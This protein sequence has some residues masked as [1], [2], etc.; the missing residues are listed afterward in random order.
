MAGAIDITQ[1]DLE[2]VF[3]ATTVRQVFCDNGSAVAGRRLQTAIST[4]RRELDAVLL[5]GWPTLDAIALLVAEDDS[6]KTLACRLVMAEGVEGKAEW[7]GEGAPFQHLRARTL[8]TLELLAAG[9]KRSAGETV[10]GKNRNARGAVSPCSP[11]TMF[12]PTRD[13]PIRRGF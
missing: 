7:S 12:A 13:K 2:A 4:A 10:A 5:K 6:I 3:P 8:A 9:Q 11:V 1:D